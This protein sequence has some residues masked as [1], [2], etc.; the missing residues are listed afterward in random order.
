MPID[1]PS[2]ATARPR[3]LGERRRASAGRWR[4]SAGWWRAPAARWRA[5]AARWRALTEWWRARP[6]PVKDRELAALLALLAFTEPLSKVAPQ[7]GDLPV[8]GIGAAGVLLTLGEVVPLAV[9]TRWPACCLAF[10]CGSFAVHEAMAYPPTF[11]GIGVYLALYSAAAHLTRH[12]GALAA[13]AT[14][15]YLGFA[16]AL[17]ALGSPERPADYGLFFL[18]LAV[19]WAAG[20]VMR[21]RRAEEA[22]RRRLA[23]ESAMAAERSRLARELH[24]VVTHHVTAMVVQADAAQFLAAAPDRLTGNLTA[25]SGTG[26][27]ALAELR[28]LLGV[29][30]ATGEGQ[31]ADRSPL[32]GKVQD[33]VEQSR[34]GGQPVEFTEEGERVTRAIGAEL[35]AY[36]IVQE[37]LTNAVKYAAG[38]RTLVRIAHT[39]EW[40]DIEVTTEGPGDGAPAADSPALRRG[41][42]H[43]S[44]GRGLGGLRDRVDLLGGEFTAGPRGDGGFGVRA[45]IPAAAA[46]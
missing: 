42:P 13:A 36:R 39:A 18:A 37:S 23:A 25:I 14:A 3:T 10:S 30:E 38:R 17:H 11:G 7:F 8:R 40:T 35:T 45:R 24:D 41:G 34:L 43:V 20:A 31:G 1:A 19:V 27:R 28:F 33:L 12:R 5:S 29:L 6:Q 15:A 22:E 26:R 21:G 44:G 4:A 9:R 32:P 46:S 2:S 16:L